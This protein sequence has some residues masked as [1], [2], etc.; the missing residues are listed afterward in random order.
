MSLS[1]IL[2][3]TL[4]YRALY[5]YIKSTI[6]PVS[7]PASNDVVYIINIIVNAVTRIM[8]FMEINVEG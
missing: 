1:K 8:S 3:T 4:F 2:T 5:S 7:D 6:V